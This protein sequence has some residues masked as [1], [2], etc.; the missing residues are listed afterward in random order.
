[1]QSGQGLL[2][3]VARRINGSENSQV[4][5]SIFCPFRLLREMAQGFVPTCDGSTAF[6]LKR[7]GSGT[8]GIRSCLNVNP[9]VFDAVG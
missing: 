7:V 3:V 8:P 9:P 2:V 5:E 4:D 1:V 6:P